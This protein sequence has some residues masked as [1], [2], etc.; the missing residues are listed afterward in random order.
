MDGLRCRF[1]R[2]VRFEDAERLQ[3]R[4]VEARLA[5]RIPNVL[6]LMQHDP[7]VTLGRRARDRHLKVSP[8]TLRARG[9]DFAVAS[10]GGDATYHGPGQW[11]LY[12][13]LRLDART[14]GLH[15]YLNRLEEIAL[16]CAGAFG[17][18]AF[19]REGKSGA[20]T[21][22]G[23]IAA[24][25]FRI[26]RWV[27]CHG[28]SFNVDV[29]LTGFQWIVPCGLHG[30]PVTSLRRILGGACPARDP[31]ADVMEERAARV[32][33]CDFQ[34]LDDAQGDAATDLRR[35]VRETLPETEQGTGGDWMLSD[36]Q[37]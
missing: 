2:P 34:P 22:A 20:W 27:T 10:R 37:S 12:P 8:E 17:V 7:V 4:L 14:S 30:E 36:S 13:I 32:L 11:V 29:D 6:L 5:D 25:G 23:K 33:Q 15:G 21:A 16:G 9:I 3:A 19:R 31:V 26:Q 18:K 24:I 28:M 35:I 1:E